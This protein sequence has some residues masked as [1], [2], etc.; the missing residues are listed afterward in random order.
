VSPIATFPVAFRG[1]RLDASAVSGAD[2]AGD[3]RLTF[4]SGD[5][6]AALAALDAGGAIVLPQA[7]AER[8]D[9]AVGDTMSVA[10]GSG[11]TVELAVAGIVERGLPSRGGEAVL[12]GWRD[13]SETFGIGG[14][15]VLAVR[16][17]DGAAESAG[18]AVAELATSLGLQPVPLERVEGAVSDALD[19]VFGLFDA[20]A[21]VAVVVAA[22]GI[23]NTLRWTSWRRG[24]EIGILRC[25]RH[26]PPR[27]DGWSSSRRASP[28]RRQGAARHRRR[29]APRSRDARAGRRTR[30]AVA[31]PG[32]RSARP[33]ARRQARHAGRLLPGSTG[34]AA[35]DHPTP[36]GQ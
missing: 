13:A 17:Q 10:G 28:R 34:R 26:T 15:D 5:R 35:L 25:R 18:P 20:L 30:R 1:L 29:A 24:P 21:L 4:V 8:L 32:R 12:V 11:A 6:A 7:Q 31:V 9:L 2:M 16:Y 36:S 3:E 27:S 19:R 33:A 22:L 23:V 14:A